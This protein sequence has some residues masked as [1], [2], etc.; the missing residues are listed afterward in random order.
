M[1]SQKAQAGKK[2]PADGPPS[3]RSGPKRR[4]PDIPTQKSKGEVNIANFVKAREFEINALEKNMRE[5][6]NS[7]STRAFQKVPRHMRRRTASHNVKKVPR[8][9]R[10]RAK[11][12]VCHS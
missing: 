2:R 9:L 6:R 7:L 12:E 11:R 4:K 8:R 5:M 1:A 3:G 10:K